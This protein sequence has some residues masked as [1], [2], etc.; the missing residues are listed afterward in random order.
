MLPFGVTQLCQT[1]NPKVHVL[2]LGETFEGCW[3][4]SVLH[5]RT[6][7]HA[8]VHGERLL[9][10]IDASISAQDGCDWCVWEGGANPRPEP[11]TQGRRQGRWGRNLALSA[12][13][14]G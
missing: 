12:V 14:L 2:L 9:W 8:L 1:Q 10:D 6:Q 11:G 7:K 5:S 13:G 4:L 3:G